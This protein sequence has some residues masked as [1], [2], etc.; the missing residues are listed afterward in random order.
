MT[1]TKFE[2]VSEDLKEK[3]EEVHGKLF[4]CPNKKCCATLKEKLALKLEK[5]DDVKCPHC[6]T[7]L[8]AVDLKVIS[9][10]FKRE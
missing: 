9:F 8:K 7:P 1:A 5:Q 6:G 2:V 10:Q 4:V 3:K